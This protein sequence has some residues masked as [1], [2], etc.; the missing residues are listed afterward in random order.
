MLTTS[1]ILWSG[2]G[3]LSFSA[4]EVPGGPEHRHELAFKFTQSVNRSCGFD[5]KKSDVS[6][7]NVW[8][9]IIVKSYRSYVRRTQS[10]MSLSNIFKS[11]RIANRSESYRIGSGLQL[12]YRGS[13]S[14]VEWR[15]SGVD[16][17]W[18]CYSQATVNLFASRENVQCVF[19]LFFFT[20]YTVQMF[21]WAQTP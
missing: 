17:I 2:G 4:M 10:L 3:H 18:A 14:R 6:S 20:P 12:M 11:H 16:Q 5:F 15:W 21:S 7:N 1:P 8:S 13:V 9:E 19:F